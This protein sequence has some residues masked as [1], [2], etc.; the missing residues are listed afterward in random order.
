MNKVSED[1]SDLIKMFND[2]LLNQ[3]WCNSIFNIRISGEKCRK[4]CFIQD[5]FQYIVYLCCIC[6]NKASFIMAFVAHGSDVAHR[7]L[8]WI[9]FTPEYKC[10]DLQ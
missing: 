3:I 1:Q 9:L 7:P 4:K 8:G 10:N 6:F 2:S 5:L